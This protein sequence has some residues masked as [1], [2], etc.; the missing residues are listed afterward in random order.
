MGDSLQEQL[1]ALGLA[2]SAPDKRK[3][4]G[5][6]GAARQSKKAAS[7]IAEPKP[8]RELTLD[9]AYA[10]REREEKQKAEQAR[11]R[12]IEEDRRR[13]QLNQAIREIVTA[14][15]QNRD[16]ADIARHF[17][18]NGRIRKIYVTAEQQRALAVDELG[19]AYL[20]GGYHLLEP[21]ALEA[22]RQLSADHVV[23]LGAEDSADDSDHPVPDDLVW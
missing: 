3:R 19:I 11:R 20:A 8:D 10:L 16:E 12:K 17:M 15:R 2:G 18:F 21:D 7:P 6:P 1:R 5:K 14:R 22:V 9:R 4:K 13:R 23:E